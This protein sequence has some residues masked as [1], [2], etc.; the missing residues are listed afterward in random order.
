MNANKLFKKTKNKK[1]EYIQDLILTGCF[2]LFRVLPV[3]TNK[4]VVSCFKNHGFCD[5]P[6]YIVL[7]LLKRNISLD[8][9]WLCDYENP[10]GMPDCIRQVPYHSFRGIYEQ[11]T[12]GVWISNRRKSRYVRKRKSQYYVQ[13]W[14]SGIRLKTIEQAAIK[15]LSKRYIESAQN[16]GKIIDLFL[17]NSNFSSSIIHR[18][19]WYSGPILQKGLP[20]SDILL[21]GDFIN[22][23]K[24]IKEYFNIPFE[25]KILLYTPTFRSSMD[26]KKYDLPSEKIIHKLEAVTK[27]KW[28]MIIHMHTNISDTTNWP[29]NSSYAVNASTYEDVQELL[30]VADALISDYS[31]IIFD[32]ALLNRPIL[33]YCPDLNEYMDGRGFNQD[34]EEL[35]FYKAY[36]ANEVLDLIAS[37]VSTKDIDTYQW[38]IKKYGLTE[39]GEASKVVSEIIL[40]KIDGGY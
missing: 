37:L 19:M 30:I 1:I 34:F 25:N 4:I 38:M 28:T 6:K 29:G 15:S 40:T 11:V 17:S 21:N 36:S 12:A 22:I 33:L 10:F 7:E 24:K 35:P 26:T 5:S 27:E 16:D 31:S 18:D 23:H 2:Y 3:K 9:V 14:H 39:T 13:T 8:I 20:R 32:F